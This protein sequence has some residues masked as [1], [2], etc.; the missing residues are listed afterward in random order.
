MLYYLFCLCFFYKKKYNDFKEGESMRDNKLSYVFLAIAL[1]IKFIISSLL[2]T[3]L[4]SFIYVFCIFVISLILIKYKIKIYNYFMLI[5][6]DFLL[7]FLM[8]FKV[9]GTNINS[10]F[11]SLFYFIFSSGYLYVLLG[12]NLS[13]KTSIKAL[14]TISNSEVD[15]G[16]KALENDNY[17]LA[18]DCFLS[19]IKQNKSN[20]LGYMGMCNTLNKFDKKNLKKIQYYKKKCIKYAPK[21]LKDNIE[22]RY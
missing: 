13:K 21:E 16:I 11:I 12:I 17:D 2:I 10:I 8:V 6:S 1:F 20:Y 19:A 7:C 15:R 4:Y 14:N 18:K 22:K 9:I 3:P 5:L